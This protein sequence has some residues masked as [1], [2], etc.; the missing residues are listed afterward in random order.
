MMKASQDRFGSDDARRAG[1]QWMHEIGWLIPVLFKPVPESDI[2]KSL[3][4]FQRVR[5]D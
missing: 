4:Q 1:P 2:P 3:R 5:F